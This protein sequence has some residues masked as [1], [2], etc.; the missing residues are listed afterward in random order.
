M[1][2]E[3]YLLDDALHAQNKLITEVL[4]K[5][6]PKANYFGVDFLFQVHFDR[7]RQGLNDLFGLLVHESLL[8]AA[9]V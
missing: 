3:K 9:G 6:L 4:E 2:G 1:I 8:D 7:I 5:K